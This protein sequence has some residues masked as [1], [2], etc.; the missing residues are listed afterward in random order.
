MKKKLLNDVI[1]FTIFVGVAA[2]AK[3]MWAWFTFVAWWENWT[4]TVGP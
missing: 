2:L 4:V 3:T 1:G